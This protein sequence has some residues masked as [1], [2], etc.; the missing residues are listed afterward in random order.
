MVELRRGPFGWVLK[1]E[2]IATVSVAVL[3]IARHPG[4]FF[5][6]VDTPRDDDALAGG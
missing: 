2:T 4:D 3:W 5:R 1:F 6:V